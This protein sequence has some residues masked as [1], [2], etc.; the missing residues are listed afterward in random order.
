MLVI[1]E[2]PRVAEKLAAALSDGGLKQK[3]LHGVKYYETVRNGKRILI[4]PAVG[5]VFSLKQKTPGSGYPV[6]DIE[7]VPAYES[8]DSADYTK[9]YLST[10][11]SLGKEAASVVNACDWDVEGSLIGGNVI[12]HLVKKPAKRMLFSTLTKEDLAE[13]FDN[14]HPLDT[15]QIEAGEAR[16][17]L[18]WYWGINTS[19]ALMAAMRKAG[20]FRIMSIGRVQGPALAILARRE[21]EISKFIPTPYWN[22]SA[23]LKGA[24][25]A[26]TAGNITDEQKAT[27][28]KKQVDEAAPAGALVTAVEEKEFKQN[29]PTPF[30]LTTLELEA[31]RAYGFKP[32][33]TLQLAQNLY[34]DAAISYPRTSSQKLS[35]KLNLKKIISD[36]SRNME[37][38]AL[39]RKLEAKGNFKPNEGEK[40]DPAHP[41]IH[42]TG[43]KPMDLGPQQ[44]KLY[45]LI[46]RRF[47]ACFGEPAK[48]ARMSVKAKIGEVDFSA[49][50][51][52]TIEKNWMEFYEKFVDLEEVTLPKFDSGERVKVDKHDLEKKMTKPPKR[53][54]EASLVKKLE[55]DDLGTKATRSEI[56]ETLFRRGYCSGKSIEVSAL[57]LS[58]YETLTK[59]VDEI[60]SEQL[61]R[62]FEKEMDDIQ[63]GKETKERVVAE[64]REM[65]TKILAKFRE[66]EAA[67]GG[68]LLGALRQ[69]QRDESLLGPCPVCA[70]EGRNGQ[71]QIRRSKY[72]QFVGC[73]A[74]PNCRN[75]YPLPKD[76]L[77][78]PA[79]KICPEC[80]TPII[81][82]IRK[83]KKPYS[84]C[85]DP[86]CKTK[87]SWGKSNYTPKAT[88]TANTAATTAPA[89][90]A[91]T[92]TQAKPTA[93]TTKA[94]PVAP[95]KTATIA[96]SG[97]P[98][99]PTAAKKP[100]TRAKKK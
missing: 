96:E 75:L 37:Y 52:R 2:K 67:I 45:D 44:A 32:S 69:T 49:S 42:P 80:N 93:P 78:K 72:G 7:W 68:E 66:K 71:L 98:A 23:I 10:L 91:Q 19:R 97:K 24:E 74:Y 16:H 83:G 54:T 30:D 6:F 33:L 70:K 13:A 22:I 15:P 82:V 62:Q 99:K 43:Q 36:L 53:Y 55:D 12:R 8:G 81:T 51:S 27:D 77:I 39:C 76:G 41:A 25:F 94:S 63:S 34:E 46:V 86:K 14:M 28:L 84:M 40:D 59:N 9:K 79:G 29:P 5:H 85:V 95:A 60:L 100:S 73:G 87:E 50:G 58:V 18:D 1:T 90:A 35:E 4:S 92:A 64:G 57:G 61:T 38:T 3:A 56:I 89:P 21:L 47:L 31:Y 17:I 48:R 11:A 26:C 88:T 20:A 65:L